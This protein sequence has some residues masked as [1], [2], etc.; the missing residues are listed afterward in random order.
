MEHSKKY[1]SPKWNLIALGFF[2]LLCTVMLY[3][4]NYGTQGMVVLVIV[5][6]P[7]IIGLTTA[8]LYALSR[9]AIRKY[10][11]ILTLIGIIIMLVITVP[12]FFGAAKYN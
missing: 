11:W 12:I 5:W 1:N 9:L 4:S 3:F 7:L 8:L 10:N 2:I 6:I